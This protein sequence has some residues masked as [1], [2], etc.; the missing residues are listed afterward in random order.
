MGRRGRGG[1]DKMIL[2][3]RGRRWRLFGMAG[4]QEE[5]VRDGELRWEERKRRTG[6]E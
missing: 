2:K 6:E 4:G 5:L 3:W 1:S